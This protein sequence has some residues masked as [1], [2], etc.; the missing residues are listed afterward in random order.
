LCDWW[1]HKG[2]AGGIYEN[3]ELVEEEEEA[4][5][6]QVNTITFIQTKQQHSVATFMVLSITVSV[7]E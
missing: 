1:L 2:Q 7:K 5:V 3:V 6:L 4:E